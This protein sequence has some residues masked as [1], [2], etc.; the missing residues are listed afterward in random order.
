[1]A[2]SG[3]RPRIDR[4]RAVR[5]ASWYDLVSSELPVAAV[6]A[7]ARLRLVTAARR[8]AVVHLRDRERGARLRV[9]GDRVATGARRHLDLAVGVTDV[10]A[11]RI[12][13][14]VARGVRRALVVVLLV[15]KARLDL[16]GEVAR[17]RL[18]VRVLALLLL[19]KERRQRDGRQDP[20]DQDHHEE[21]DKGEAL[22]LR[23]DAL[24]ELPQHVL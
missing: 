9:R 1:M 8:G 19:A 21:L 2:E 17:V 12:A 20:D 18:G 11:G 23:V 4:R 10:E 22:L 14:D 13:V 5:P 15:R 6:G 3:R 7:A 16:R 24:G